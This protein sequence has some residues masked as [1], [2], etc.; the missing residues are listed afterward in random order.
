MWCTGTSTSN[1]RVF[2][3]Y[4]TRVQDGKAEATAAVVENVQQECSCFQR[5][6]LRKTRI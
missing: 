5:F 3:M 1:Y 6:L 2:P 4:T